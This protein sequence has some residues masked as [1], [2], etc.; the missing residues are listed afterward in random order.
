MP[1]PVSCASA[2]LGI[3]LQ[4]KVVLPTTD[5]TGLP[6]RLPP[7]GEHSGIQGGGSRATTGAATARSGA[8]AARTATSQGALVNL[9]HIR[10]RCVGAG[11]ES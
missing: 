3:V 9:T 8:A 1:G 6:I 2:A 5:P 10:Q 7:A 11:V 4:C